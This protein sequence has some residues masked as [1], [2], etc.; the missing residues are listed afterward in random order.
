MCSLAR[1]MHG[2]LGSDAVNDCDRRTQTEIRAWQSSRA[3]SATSPP[4]PRAPRDQAPCYCACS[5]CHS[6]RHVCLAKKKLQQ[7]PLLPVTASTPL[8]SLALRLPPLPLQLFTC[9]RQKSSVQSLGFAAHAAVA[10]EEQPCRMG[11]NTSG[12]KRTL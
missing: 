6:L 8:V 9:T 1:G 2:P 11:C 10:A 5:R 4:R 7:N 12:H 3:F